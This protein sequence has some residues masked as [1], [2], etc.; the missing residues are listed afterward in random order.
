MA[1]FISDL[2]ICRRGTQVFKRDVMSQNN[3]SELNVTQQTKLIFSFSPALAARYVLQN[4]KGSLF[5]IS[6]T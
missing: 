6:V 3:L 1:V 2:R 4:S 5:R